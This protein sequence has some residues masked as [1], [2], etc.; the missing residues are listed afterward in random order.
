MNEEIPLGGGRVTSGVARIGDTVRRPQSSNAAFVHRL[1][2]DLEEV[3]FDASPRLL[4]IDTADREIL[5]FVEGDVPSD[6]GE[7]VWDDV[8]LRAAAQ[9]LRRFHD[10]TATSPLRDASEVVCHNDFGPWNL[11]WRD[12]LPIAIIDFDNA[13][14]GSRADDLSYAAWKH[15]NL[16]LIEL[17][18]EQQRH[19]LS[20]FADG[21]G[22]SVDEELLR[23]MKRAQERMHTLI[24]IA[25]DARRDDALSQIGLEQRWLRA[26]GRQLIG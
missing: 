12:E 20:V 4:G 24:D 2:R 18:V 17:P 6:C 5:R 3:G 21:Y 11:V 26:D 22:A 23:A 7:L 15:L 13:A 19:R 10:A 16:G 25:T 1:L 14:P 8:Q 9:L